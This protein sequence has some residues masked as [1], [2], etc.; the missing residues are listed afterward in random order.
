M[1][2]RALA[3]KDVNIDR[4]LEA[5]GCGEDLAFADGEGG[6][7]LNDAGADA[8]ERLDAE[9][10]RRDVEQQKPLD[11]AGENAA[12]KAGSHRN[13][14][15]GIDALEGERAGDGLD[16]ILH[17]RNAARTADHQ[18]LADLRDADAGVVDGL[19]DRLARGLHQ[20]IG[21]VVELR[22]RQRD[23][24]VQRAAFADGDVGKAHRG[25][26]HGGKLD[27]GFFRSL[28]Q[29]LHG[30]RVAAEVELVLIF[31]F[32]DQIIDDALVKIVA[33]EAVVAR[34]GEH[35]ND[36]CRDVED[37]HVK[38]AA[39][40]I[41]D[42]D[43]LRLLAI[44][45][46]GK[47]GGGRFVDDALHVQPRDFAGILGG[48]TLGVGEV[49]G[50]GDDGVR[51]R[52]AEIAFRIA[53][54]LLQDHGGDLLRG[55][56]VPVDVQLVIC[57]HLALDRGDRALVVGDGLPLCKAADHPLAG[58]GKAHNRGRGTSALGIR[59]DDRLAAFH[60]GNAGIGGAKVD[61]DDFG[62]SVT[63]LKIERPRQINLPRSPLRGG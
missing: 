11:A 56:L 41:V 35:L 26:G 42:H 14:L 33:A 32:L 31:E 52:L 9:R 50:D 7:A 20:M 28:A 29:P 1:R 60:H 47:G 5:R 61:T 38:R 40:E 24:H 25:G 23:V 18:H 22:P 15:V 63:L 43:L 49:G 45:A 12:L 37:G 10:Q 54:E 36:A 4:G 51:D 3:L 13:A 21:E 27:L 30:C 34:G 48:L 62:H 39:A 55:I 6:V 8:A 19:I 58:R 53:L 46:V 44:N 57:A 16:K 2:H 59:D 17:G